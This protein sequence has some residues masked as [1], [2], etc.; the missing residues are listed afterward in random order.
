[1]WL[2]DVMEN[3]TVLHGKQDGMVCNE[4]WGR[5]QNRWDG[6]QWDVREDGLGWRMV[7]DRQEWDVTEGR[8]GREG[9]DGIRVAWA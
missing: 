1:M 3:R 6:S 2:G 8:R 5:G 4:G 7:Q 9:W